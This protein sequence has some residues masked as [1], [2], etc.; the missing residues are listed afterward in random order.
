M[1]RHARMAFYAAGSLLVA[2]VASLA[3]A[4]WL[5]SFAPCWIE[6]PIFVLDERPLCR[7][8][9]ILLRAASSLFYLSLMAVAIAVLL[10]VVGWRASPNNRVWTP[11]SSTEEMNS[12]SVAVGY[13]SCC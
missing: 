10:C 12:G 5:P 9:S 6:H 11:P 7:E 1:T 13:P 4:Y 8:L 2:S 3:L